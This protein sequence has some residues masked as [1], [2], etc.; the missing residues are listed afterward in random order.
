MDAG[1]DFPIHVA[2]ADFDGSCDVVWVLGDSNTCVVAAIRIGLVDPG[3]YPFETASSR[4]TRF[5]RLDE[6]LKMKLL[7]L[8]ATGLV[9][10]KTL[11]LALSQ[12]A[13]FEVVA[14]TRKALAPSDRL[15]NPVALRLEELA[16]SLASFK[17]E[18]VI[19][20]LGTTQAIAGSKEAFRDVDYE[21]PLTFGKAAHAAGVETFA[22]V[23]AM[24]ASE[25]S[26]ILYSRTKG[27]VEQDIQKIGFR[28]L[29]ICRPS[30]IGGERNESRSGESAALKAVR[31]L[32]P[33]LPKKL[34]INPADVI[35]ARLLKAVLDA[36]AGCRWIYADEMN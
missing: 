15:L 12:G 27:E 2:I 3:N 26:R 28:S 21:L 30:L 17:V 25:N 1:A 8:G 13:L 9:G 4:L 23:T 36:K 5:D 11:K 22:I 16:P 31:F 33:I 10:S 35:A 18:A 29:T 32:A 20:A 7:L 14:P 19:C 24:G 34:R 6:G